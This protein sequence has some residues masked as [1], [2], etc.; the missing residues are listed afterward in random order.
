MKIVKTSDG[1]EELFRPIRATFE[2]N[3]P[4]EVPE[5]I[6]LKLIERFDYEEVKDKIIE[7]KKRRVK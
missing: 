2:P 5:S 4:V 6:G 1:I 7:S 3:I